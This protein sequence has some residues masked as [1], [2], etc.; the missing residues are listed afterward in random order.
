MRNVFNWVALPFRILQLA[1]QLH[2]LGHKL[3]IWEVN[4]LEECKGEAD[5]ILAI[6]NFL[7]FYLG[8]KCEDLVREN[9]QSYSLSFAYTLVGTYKNP[10]I[11]LLCMAAEAS[12]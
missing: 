4:C 3:P 9:S 10:S 12:T 7:P 6:L 5:E 8:T 2:F 1:F 11:N